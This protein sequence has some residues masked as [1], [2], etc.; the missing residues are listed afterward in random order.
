MFLY[1][2]D[3]VNI[4]KENKRKRDDGVGVSTI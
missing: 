3:K 4:M 2:T 1:T